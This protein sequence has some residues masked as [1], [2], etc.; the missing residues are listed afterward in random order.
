MFRKGDIINFSSKYIR[1]I[2]CYSYN[3]YKFPN[4]SITAIQMRY[5][6]TSNKKIQFNNKNKKQTQTGIVEITKGSI[7]INPA[8]CSGCGATFQSTYPSS[9]GYLSSA[10]MADH[11]KRMER[12]KAVKDA[13][14]VLNVGGID[15]KSDAAVDN[16]TINY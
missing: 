6:S 10:K 1:R 12:R 3:G 14:K 8:L 13:L 9:S 11:L 16:I 4:G 7:D 2:T 15:V 5:Q